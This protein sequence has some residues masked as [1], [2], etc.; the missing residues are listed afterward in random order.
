MLINKRKCL[1]AAKK[2][3]ILEE[4]QEKLNQARCQPE[5]NWSEIIKDEDFLKVTSFCQN[6]EI[7]VKMLGRI[8]QT[9]PEIKGPRID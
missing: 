2:T 6:P 3:K 1:I 4:A 7:A 9:V 5:K 8:I